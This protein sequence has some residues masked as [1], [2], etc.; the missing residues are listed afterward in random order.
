[1][2]T[3]PLNIDSQHLGTLFGDART[4]IAVTMAANVKALFVQMP[5]QFQPA[6]GQ[7]CIMTPAP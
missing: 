6:L 2:K 3:K 1:L 4:R 7:G 5:E